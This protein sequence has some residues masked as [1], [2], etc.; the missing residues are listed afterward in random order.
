MNQDRMRWRDRKMWVDVG[1][2]TIVTTL[3]ALQP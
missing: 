1:E 3:D 2:K